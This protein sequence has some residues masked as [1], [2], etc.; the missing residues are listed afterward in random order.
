MTAPV[1]TKRILR[2]QRAF[3]A[4]LNALARPGTIERIDPLPDVPSPF[5]LAAALLEAVV[6][7]EVT[8]AIAPG[9]AAVEEAVLRRTGSIVGEPATADYVVTTLSALPAT[10]VAVKA[11]SPEFPDHSATV[12]TVVPGFDSGQSLLIEGP[13]IPGSTPIAIEGWTPAHTQA[14]REKNDLL[15]QGVDLVLVDAAGCLAAFTRYTRIMEVN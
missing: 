11:G 7:H 9:N 14:F 2:E 5:A 3:R 8:F 4:M 6:D 1:P 12:V 10:L 15:P 13:G